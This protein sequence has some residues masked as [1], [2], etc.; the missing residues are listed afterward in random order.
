MSLNEAV[1]QFL[2]YCELDRN[3]AQKTIRMYGYY[4]IFFKSWIEKNF[5]D[6]ALDVT[7]ISDQDLRRFRL[8]LSQVYRNQYKGPLKRQSQN[9]FLI[10][11][12]SM[13]RYLIREEVPV[14]SPDKIDLGKTRDR[15][16]KFLTPEDLNR[17]FQ[18]PNVKRLQGLR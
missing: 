5:P 3:L 18:T 11:I 12:R 8:Y 1:L 2:E 15:D 4:L 13:L 9:Y 16:I 10:A 6:D 14:M 17:L 7:K